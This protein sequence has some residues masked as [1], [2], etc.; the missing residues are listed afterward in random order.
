MSPEL[1]EALVRDFPNLY[2]DRHSSMKTTA[3]CFGFACDDGW[4]KIIRDL[5]AKLEVLI[6]ALPQDKREYCKAVQV[7]EKFAAL[8]YY[9]DD[10]T[11]EMYSLINEAEKLS[12]ETCEL[13]GRPG[14]VR[15]DHWIKTL[16]DACELLK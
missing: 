14:S 16:C 8:R 5:S 2:R 7:K 9:M 4:H 3:M 10:A 15:G 1:D 12:Y 13:C 11:Q 6:L